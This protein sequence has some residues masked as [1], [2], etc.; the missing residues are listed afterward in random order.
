MSNRILKS[1]PIIKAVDPSIKRPLWSVMIPTFNCLAFLRQTMESVLIQDPGPDK[2]QIE[3]VDDCSS[4]G[5]VEALV[6]EVGK[7]RIGFFRQERNMGHHRN[8]ETCLN[9]SK[10]E[11]IHFLHGDDWVRPGFYTEIESL[12]NAHPQIGAAFTK[13]G[14]TDE[15]NT[16]SIPEN[17]LLPAP[18]ILDDFLLN[19]AQKQM[20]QVVAMVVKRSVYEKLGGFFGVNYCEDWLMWIRIAA[21]FPV[22]YSPACLAI[23]RGGQGNTASIT[24]NSLLNGENFINTEKAIEMVQPYLPKSKRRY[25]KS[26]AKK[27]YSMHIAK[28]SNLMYQYSPKAAFIQ[29]KGAVKMHQNIR[30]IYWVMKLYMLHFQKNISRKTGIC[31]QCSNNVS[32]QP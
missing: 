14:Y 6:Q 27:N 17:S 15:M 5:D 25:I 10:G 8:F 32:V 22:A 7:G 18:G 16:I 21:D 24:S 1:P 2:M 23:Y 12:F 30:A 20:L 3:V 11:L 13:N 29:A 4:D 28:A 31:R 19:I 26:M 9:R